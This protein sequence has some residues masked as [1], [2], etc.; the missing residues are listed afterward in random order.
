MQFCRTLHITKLRPIKMSNLWCISIQ[1]ALFFQLQI[2][3]RYNGRRYKIIS[4]IQTSRWRWYSSKYSEAALFTLK[5]KNVPTYLFMY[6]Y[7]RTVNMHWF[8]WKFSF[9]FHTHTSLKLQ[10]QLKPKNEQTSEP[11][12]VSWGFS[13]QV[14]AF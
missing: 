2:P 1:P 5:K 10:L 3:V 8:H 9:L 4:N 11:S 6:M 14:P 7:N 12:R 13:L